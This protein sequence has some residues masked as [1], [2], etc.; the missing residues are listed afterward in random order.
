MSRSGDAVYLDHAAST[1]LR[2]EV[3]E[4]ML[5]VFAH[6]HGN[7]SSASMITLLSRFS[8]FWQCL[9]RDFVKNAAGPTA[10]A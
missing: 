10:A 2:A 9:P 7:P 5:E 4:A 8:Q 1:P 6:R 3:R